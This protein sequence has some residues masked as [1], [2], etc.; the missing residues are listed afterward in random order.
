MISN[1]LEKI[2][3]NEPFSEDLEAFL[4]ASQDTVSLAQKGGETNTD[5]KQNID[6]SSQIPEND[7]D[8]E[9]PF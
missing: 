3:Q 6:E 7:L 8:D 9:I 4:D 5:K 1:I 2:F